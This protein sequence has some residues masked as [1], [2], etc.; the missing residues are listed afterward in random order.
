M[1]L[2]VATALTMM[3]QMT[4]MKIVLAIAALLFLLVMV[5]LTAVGETSLFVERAA[6][7]VIAPLF[8][9][10]FL[11]PLAAP[12]LASFAGVQKPAGFLLAAPVAAAVGFALLV[13]AYS[14]DAPRGLSILHYKGDG[15]ERALWAISRRE[16][17]PAAMRAAA[18]FEAGEAPGLPGE[19]WVASAPD[20]DHAGLRV[21]ILSDTIEN[22]ERIVV[23]AIAAPDADRLF[24]TFGD[25]DEAAR[26]VSSLALNG[27]TIAFSEADSRQ[28][29]CYGRACRAFE[30]TVVLKAE[31]PAPELALFAARHGLGPES[32]DLANARPNWALPQHWGDLRVVSAP[33]PLAAN[34]AAAGGDQ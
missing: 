20:F 24:M 8:L 15:M 30:M 14:A 18:A 4:A 29:A 27:Q 33:L 28:F 2:I 12:S 32:A 31:A 13:P 5:P 10:I 1:L 7:F 16:P 23:A 6:P 21:E 19:R 3:K 17:A 9:F 34:E 22:G 25:K 11:A 26:A